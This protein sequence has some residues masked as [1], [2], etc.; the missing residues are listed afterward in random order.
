[1]Q[2]NELKIKCRNL[3]AEYEDVL[4]YLI[5]ERELFLN[6]GLGKI[7]DNDP[8]NFVRKMSHQQGLIEGMRILLAEIYKQTK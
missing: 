4:L 3:I 7:R 2:N 6:K 5:G 1:M 8:I